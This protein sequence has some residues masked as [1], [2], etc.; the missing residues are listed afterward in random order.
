MMK[1]MK[2]QILSRTEDLTRKLAQ[3]LEIYIKHLTARRRMLDQPQAQKRH[4]SIKTKTRIMHG[5]IW[6]SSK[7]KTSKLDKVVP[8]LT[9]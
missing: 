1:L 3:L 7:A 2:L 4:S 8:K 5:T 9:V 6:V